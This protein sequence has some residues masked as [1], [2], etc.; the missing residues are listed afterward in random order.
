MS[1]MGKRCIGTLTIEF[2][3]INIARKKFQHQTEAQHSQELVIRESV[4]DAQSFLG[5][6]GFHYK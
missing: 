1:A 6:T 3:R 2:L 5:L 4:K